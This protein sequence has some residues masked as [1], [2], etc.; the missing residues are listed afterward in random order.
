MTLCTQCNAQI[1]TLDRR[2]RRVNSELHQLGLTYHKF[3]PVASVDS[4]LRANGFAETSC[5]AFQPG[6]GV[7]RI[8]EEVGDGKWLT[9]HAYKMASGNWEVVAYVN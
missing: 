2:Q 5:W 4:A 3:L 8:H 6:H 7:V 1:P 9:L